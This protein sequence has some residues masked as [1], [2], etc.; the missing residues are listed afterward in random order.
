MNE[1]KYNSLTDIPNLIDANG[2]YC[3]SSGNKFCTLW[4]LAD[5][6]ELGRHKTLRRLRKGKTL[7]EI[8]SESKVNPEDVVGTAYKVF[9]RYYPTQESI[10][11]AYGVTDSVIGTHLDNIE[12]YLLSITYISI[13]GKVYHS[14]TE[15]A[16]DFNLTLP[17]LCHR[18]NRG[19]TLREALTTPIRDNPGS[20]KP[21]EDHLGNT[22]PSKAAMCTAYKITNFTYNYRE[23]KG[24]DLEKI[25]TTPVNGRRNR[26]KEDCIDDLVSD[27]RSSCQ[28]V[29]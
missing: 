25:L 19:M 15:L 7:R 10:A 5:A 12:E 18:L 29:E 2:C 26:Y 16:L 4:D 3:D 17:C 8:L 9:G 1:Y 11:A 23:R 22:Y 13:D 20:S 27:A 24:W 6:Y 14:Y 21:C 28:V